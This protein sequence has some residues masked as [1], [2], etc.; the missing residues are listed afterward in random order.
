MILSAHPGLRASSF[1]VSAS[2][3]SVW[4]IHKMSEVGPASFSDCVR[5]S[6]V[7]ASMAARRREDAV[8]RAAMKLILYP[9]ALSAGPSAWARLPA[10]I[11]VIVALPKRAIQRENIRRHRGTPLK[12][13]GKEAA[14]E[15]KRNWELRGLRG[16]ANES[17]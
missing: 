13:G 3:S 4:Q 15:W 17:G 1:A 9:A 12:H 16:S 2:A 14:E 7:P 8:S 10:P 11:R 6:S 5:A